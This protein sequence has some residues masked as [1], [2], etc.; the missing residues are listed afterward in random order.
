M[1]DLNSFLQKIKTATDLSA[2]DTLEHTLFGRKN[3]LVTVAMKDLKNLEPNQKKDRAKELNTAKKSLEEAIEH[4][5]TE[6]QTPSSNTL[7]TEDKLDVTLNIPHKEHG[8]LHLIPEF[9]RKVEEV[10]GRMGF[11]IS[12]GPEIEEDDYNFTHLNIPKDHPARDTQDTFWLKDIDKL[13]RTHTSAIQCR[14]MHAAKPPFRIMYHG[15][16]YRKDADATHSP[17]FHQFETL[18]IDKKISLA[19]M[20]GVIT[21]AMQ[22]L[23]DDDELEFRFRA[24]YFPFTEPSMEIDMSWKGDEEDSRE[25]KWL[26]VAGCGLVHPNVLKAG[27]LDPDEWQGFAFAFG[28]ERM[29]MIKHQIPDLRAFY[30]GDPRFLRQF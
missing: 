10:F 7:A 6:L 25:G 30:S 27:G 1:Q 18:M 28:V 8:H 15:K 20:K 4:K 14:H 5:R 21:S 3:G 22:E 13:L 9:I 2:L 23:M 26:E 12:P 29:I 11:E 16:C 19:D 17:M 24:S